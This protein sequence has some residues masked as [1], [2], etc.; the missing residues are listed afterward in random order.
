MQTVS[1]DR[2]V[3]EV[4]AA[5]T[6]KAYAALPQGQARLCGCTDCKNWIATRDAA[7][8]SEVASLLVS[9]GIDR[10]KETEL[11]EYEGGQVVEGRNLY[12]GEYLFVGS[13]QSG[14][15]CYT[16]TPD[17]KGCTI[18][19]APVVGSFQLGFSSQLQ[20]AR[21]NYPSFPRER[22]AVLVFQV[23]GQRGVAYA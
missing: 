2:W 20:W 16:A 17:G 1:F 23:H 8:P 13:R 7:F 14:P 18:E 6:A 3:L 12:W 19:L 10:S 9:L 22:T 21:S 11:S 15:E 4:D 5:A